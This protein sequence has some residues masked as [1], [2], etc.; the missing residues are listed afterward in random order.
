VAVL[1]DFL[2]RQTRIIVPME[3]IG[4]S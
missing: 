3:V 1:L 2:G 4:R